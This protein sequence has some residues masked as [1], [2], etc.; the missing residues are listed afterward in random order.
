MGISVRHLKEAI[1]VR[2][3]KEAIYTTGHVIK[4]ELE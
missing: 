1:S 3:L 2:H 4:I